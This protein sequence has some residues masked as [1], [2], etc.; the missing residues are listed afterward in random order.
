MKFKMML[1]SRHF[2]QNLQKTK[3]NAVKTEYFMRVSSYI[4][5]CVSMPSI[6]SFACLDHTEIR[7]G[8][9]KTQNLVYCYDPTG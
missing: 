1:M 9:N 4:C 6:N 7:K 3:L 8:K 5:M 2:M